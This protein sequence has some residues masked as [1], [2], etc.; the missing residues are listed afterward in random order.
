MRGRAV[1]AGQKDAVRGLDST[2]GEQTV[3]VLPLGHQCTTI[4]ATLGYDFTIRATL[5]YMCTIWATLGPC[6]LF[7]QHYGTS[8]LLG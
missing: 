3:A 5:G 8:V 4:Q 6:V 7:W 1:G 2:L